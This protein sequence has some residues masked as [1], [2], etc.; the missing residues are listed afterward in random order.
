MS[1]TNELPLYQKLYQLTKILYKIFKNAPKQYKYSIVQD[2][3]TFCWQC[4]DLLFDI[5]VL[6]NPKKHELI[7]LLSSNFDKLKLR[8]RM[9]QELNIISKKQFSYI[10]ENYIKEIGV[11]I[12]G[13]LKWS[14]NL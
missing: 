6:E 4:L 1:S 13:W 14:K 5:N 3:L 2:A 7:V 9:M 11:M 8:L 10:Y 12:G